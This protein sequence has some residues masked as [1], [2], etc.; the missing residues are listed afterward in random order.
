MQ[1][2]ILVHAVFVMAAACLSLI[3]GKDNQFEFS[4]NLKSQHSNKQILQ[5]NFLLI[6][7]R[8]GEIVEL[9]YSPKLGKNQQTSNIQLSSEKESIFIHEQS[10]EGNNK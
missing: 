6:M 7:A 1:P 3:F 5:H 4:E 10:Q 8:L 9:V 2:I